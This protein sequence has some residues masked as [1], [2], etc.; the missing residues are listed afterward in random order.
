MHFGTLPAAPSD[1][2]VSCLSSSHNSL[3][4]FSFSIDSRLLTSLTSDLQLYLCM[5][6]KAIRAQFDVL[7]C[8]F[9]V[10]RDCPRDN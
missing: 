1:G 6:V 10:F 3:K 7:L 9:S 2:L 4:F 5:D 8:C